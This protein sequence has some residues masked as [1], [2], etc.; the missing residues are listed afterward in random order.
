M[1]LHRTLST[2]SSCI[3]LALHIQLIYLFFVK[4]H[5]VTEPGQTT[6]LYYNKSP[7]QYSP[8]MYMPWVKVQRSEGLIGL[9]GKEQ[10]C[11][12]LIW[13]YTFCTTTDGFHK[14]GPAICKYHREI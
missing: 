14:C 3:C 5:T 13:T 11:N 7:R 9:I 6:C 2:T 10:S 1:E 12:N 4:C 8:N